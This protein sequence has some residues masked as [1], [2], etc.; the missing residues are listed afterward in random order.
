M[1]YRPV[2]GFSDLYAGMDGS[3]VLA[4]RGNLRQKP[5]GRGGYHQV[6]IPAPC[7]GA[8]AVAVYR[9]IAAAFLGPQPAGMCVRHVDGDS[10]NSQLNNLCYGTPKDN[11]QDS[12]KHGTNHHARKTHCAKGHE[13]TPENTYIRPGTSHRYCR[14]CTASN[15]AKY[16]AVRY[17]PSRRIP[18]H[19][20][21]MIQKFLLEHPHWSN[22][23]IAE[24]AGVSHTAV[25][26]RRLTIFGMG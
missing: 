15:T 25:R 3:I 11:A 18:E 10:K 9:L 2:P 26:F 6:S 21:V 22:R 7:G 23:S 12:V 24:R 14:K 19:K 13:Y 8:T 20:E 4:G 17:D 16:N 5:R 1:I